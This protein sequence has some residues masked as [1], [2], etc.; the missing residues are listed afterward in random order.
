MAK[1]EG[2]RN[3]GEADDSG[4]DTV[5]QNPTG[6]PRKSSARTRRKKERRLF[7]GTPWARQDET[8]ED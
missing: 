5:G 6:N 7:G 8:K 4:W 1:I 2:Y 3:G